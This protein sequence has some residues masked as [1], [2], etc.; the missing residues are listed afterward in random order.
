MKPGLDSHSPIDAHVAQL[1]LVSSHPL[2]FLA[3]PV[4]S[5]M[6]QLHLHDVPMYPGFESHSPVAA[7]PSQDLVSSAQPGVGGAVAV[8]CAL[9]WDDAPSRGGAFAT[10]GSSD[11]ARALVRVSTAPAT[12]LNAMAAAPTTY[13]EMP[14]LFASRFGVAGLFLPIKDEYRLQRPH[15]IDP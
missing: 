12:A 15:A 13:H 5:Q 6:P 1:V 11:N 4:P 14:P 10:F 2:R 9:R 7:Q 3:T 8:S